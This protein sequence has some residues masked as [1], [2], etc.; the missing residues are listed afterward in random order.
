MLYSGNTMSEPNPI[1]ERIK[2]GM[3]VPARRKPEGVFMEETAGKKYD[4]WR[5]LAILE[6]PTKPDEPDDIWAWIAPVGKEENL[7]L[8]NTN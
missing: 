8:S 2:G 4:G 1:Y 7:N 5:L 3:L 6:R